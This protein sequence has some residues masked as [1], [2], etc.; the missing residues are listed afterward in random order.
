M[1]EP[2]GRSV[3]RAELVVKVRLPRRRRP[4]RSGPP[5]SRAAVEAGGRRAPAARPGG[6]AASAAPCRARRTARSRS[7]G[8]CPCR[9]QGVAVPAGGMTFARSPRPRPP[10]WTPG[11]TN[12]IDR[13]HRSLAPHRRRE[14]DHGRRAAVDRLLG[15]D[16]PVRVVRLEVAVQPQ[17]RREVLGDVRLVQPPRVVV[18]RVTPDAGARDQVVGRRPAVGDACGRLARGRLEHRVRRPRRRRCRDR[19]SCGRLRR[20]ERSR[21]RSRAA[22][23]RPA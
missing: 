10:F 1:A 9:S 15:H 8:R 4:R 14:R 5:G 11:R 7:A 3:D 21:R 23:A 18:D 6:R 16:E 19:R 13:N 22:R 17:D 2:R 12:S 20:R